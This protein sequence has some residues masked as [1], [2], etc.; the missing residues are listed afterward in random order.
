[1]S[2]THTHPDDSTPPQSPPPWWTAVQP[3][4]KS[5]L[6]KVLIYVGVLVLIISMVCN[7]YLAGII[8][9]MTGSPMY[10]TT[11]RPGDEQQIVATYAIDG[12]ITS[13][14]ASEFA[15]FYRVVRDTPAIKA[16][17]VRVDSP[18]GSVA[19][20]DEIHAMI[21]KIREELNKPVVISMGG[22]AASGG[23]Y[24]S[25]PADMIFAEPTTITAS[26][27]VIFPLPVAHDFLEEHGINMIMVRSTQ[28]QRYKAAINYFEKPDP[29]V[30]RAR[31]ALL[32]DMH[33][34]FV[35]VV[36]AGRGDKI[37]TKAISVT[38]KDFD[39]KDVVREQT[40]PFNG[41]VVFGDEAKAIGLVDEIGYIDDAVDAAIK[42]AKLDDPTVTQYSRAQ[43]LLSQLMDGPAPPAPGFD[44][45]ILERYLSPRPMM[46]WEG[47]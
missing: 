17:V 36:K 47:Q 23:Y 12:V 8:R 13:F 31:Q 20:S 39:G 21:K 27:G 43:G 3:K 29:E 15:R 11:L 5:T 1:L 35:A 33:E 24:V 7:V 44:M 45:K 22:A 6:R 16:V 2:E 41:Q 46:L 37:K 25:A 28:S 42:L 18:G 4:K 38:V 26:I 19:P 40:F 32:D 30:L 10:T 14:T 9:L 34:K